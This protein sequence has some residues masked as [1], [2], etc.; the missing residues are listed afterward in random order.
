[1]PNQAVLVLDDS[2]Q[3]AELV[4]DI[5]GQAGYRAIPVSHPAQALV[6]LKGSFFHLVL[7]DLSMP[8]MSGM[9]VLHEAKQISPETSVVI[10]TAYGTIENAVE[11]IKVGAADYLTKPFSTDQLLITVDR[12]LKSQQVVMEN[13]LLKERLEASGRDEFDLVG[14]HPSMLRIK[15][16]I[17]RVAQDSR[18]PVLI[19]GESG[20]GKELAARA[21]HRL[22][23]RRDHPFIAVN[24][25]A[26]PVGLLE[27]ELFGHE[28]GAFTGA[29]A[30]RLGRFMLADSGT[31]FLDE[32]GEMDISMQSKL[33]RVLQ[34]GEFMMVGG[35]RAQHV[36]VRVISATNRNLPQEVAAGRF[37]EDLYYRLNVIPI[38]LPPLRERASDLQPLVDCFRQQYWRRHGRKAPG[39]GPEAQ[40][41][42][43]GYSF[44]GNVRELFNL[45]E[46]GS[47][48]AHGP[49][50]EAED[51]ALPCPPIVEGVRLSLRE[52]GEEAQRQTLLEALERHD[53][54]QRLTSA[55]LG[56]SERTLRYRLQRYGLRKPR[57]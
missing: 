42:L 12:V 32:I 8:E 25:A 18:T 14:S 50:I 47:L 55:D 40:A 19:M 53:W 51:L 23:A 26:L 29:A 56:V 1:M 30:R 46:R 15:E 52:A 41:A 24:C 28:K 5:L 54:N 34:E 7:T 37:R 16:L 33:L 27:S 9:Q 45:L 44:P 36:D 10:M 17:H 3:Q 35:T 38:T 31:L 49:Q 22:S 43:Q 57:G 13:Q 20:T 48:L 11:A 4:S 21:I 2:L 39:L 6:E